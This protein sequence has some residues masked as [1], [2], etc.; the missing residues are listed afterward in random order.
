[1]HT[2]AQQHII[3]GGGLIGLLSAYYLRE[4]GQKVTVVDKG[5]I[6]KE[7]SWAGGGILSPLYP[8]RY[9]D[10]VTELASWSQNAY[11]DLIQR[12]SRDT[13]ID[14]QLNRCGLMILD[15]SDINTAISWAERYRKPIELIPPSIQ[16]KIAPGINPDITPKQALWLPDIAQIRNPRMIKALAMH[17]TQRGV[18]ILENMPVSEIATHNHRLKGIVVN[19]KMMPASSVTVACGA[20]S[21]Q[22]LKNH[23][24]ALTIEPVK[25]QMIIFKAIPQLLTP[26]LLSDS[27]YLIPRLDGRILAGST[28][29]YVGFDKHKT[30]EAKNQLHQFATKLYPA[31]ADYPVEHHWSGL[32]P[33]SATQ[34]P[35]ICQHPDINGLYINTG[36]F[37]NGVV[38]APASARLLV[39]LI[40]N[41]KP[42]LDRKAYIAQTYSV[43]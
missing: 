32:R 5:A 10:A 7:S 34:I 1:M 11:P 21:S 17:L 19:G 3:I 35:L 41:N 16:K 36:H 22:L 13:Q 42:I 40:L 23:P 18:P 27:H 12:L 29:E 8:W 31:L 33:G 15:E 25:G 28:L 6:G 30:P 43:K 39:D 26:L 24:V 38:T 20:W 37:R 2:T 4:A 14:A 9:P